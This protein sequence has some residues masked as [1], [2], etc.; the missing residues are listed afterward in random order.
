MAKTA[1]LFPGPSGHV[2]GALEPLVA[3]GS[4]RMAVLELIDE[5]S[6]RHGWG[7]VSPM[8]LL[9]GENGEQHAGHTWLGFFAT[10]LIV[11]DVLREARVGRDVL[12][13]HSGGEVSALVVAG[14]MGVEDAAEVLV[15]RTEVVEA[16]GLP[17][18]GM[19]A[20]EAPVVRVRSLCAAV[21]DPSVR[22]AVD[23]GPHQVVVSGL[24]EGVERLERAATALG[25]KTTRLWVPAAYHNPVLGVA[26]RELVDRTESIPM[27]APLTRVYSPQL[28]RDIVTADD[29]RELLAGTLL[30]PVGFRTALRRLYD[31]GVR[32]FVEC[33]GKQVLSDLVPQNLPAQAHAVPTL[34]SR[35]QAR[36]LA[37][38]IGELAGQGRVPL[39]IPPVTVRPAAAVAAVHSGPPQSTGPVPA[40]LAP[41]PSHMSA[42]AQV[43]AAHVAVAPATD[44]VSPAAGTVSTKLPGELE[45]RDAVRQ[46]F[47]D[48][49]QF[50]PEVVEDDIELEA[51][52]GVS[53][54]KHT[55]ALTQLL[56]RFGLPTPPADVKAFQRRTVGQVAA[57]LRELAEDR[58]VAGGQ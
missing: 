27:R 44:T 16:S 13:G 55:Q 58:S 45:L 3:P 43:T 26:A 49:L 12:V 29:A 30:L 52:L 11:S 23:N 5:V 54:L 37:Q 22:V 10:S 56:D 46:V 33:G 48:L 18:S 40:S 19:L 17:E 32:T 6:V 9:P 14:A 2:A 42:S 28:G 24:W 38:N 34:T 36:T 50:P 53:S 20:V 47:A 4:A 39:P 8:L 31:E 7:P 35:V 1:W 41:F 57:L 15:C 51:E 21:G 25:V